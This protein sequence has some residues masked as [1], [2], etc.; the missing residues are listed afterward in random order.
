MSYVCFTIACHLITKF[1]TPGLCQTHGLHIFFSNS[2]HCLV[3]FVE[4]VRSREVLNSD[5]IE[6]TVLI[7]DD[8]F[9]ICCFGLLIL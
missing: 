2:L 5:D 7:R 6:P 8:L 3:T 9:P 1:Y 4:A